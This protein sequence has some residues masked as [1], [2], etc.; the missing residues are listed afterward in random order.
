MYC[1]FAATLESL[2]EALNLYRKRGGGGFRYFLTPRRRMKYGNAMSASNIGRI[3]SGTWLS[4]VRVMGEIDG[5][6]VLLDTGLFGSK[7]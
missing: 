5:R 3:L 2:G 4:T 7:A 6:Y 1:P